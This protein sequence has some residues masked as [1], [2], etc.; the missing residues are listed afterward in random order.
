MDLK[1]NSIADFNLTC[2]DEEV[3]DS[4]F[5]NEDFIKYISRN[6]KTKCKSYLADDMYKYAVTR[7]AETDEIITFIMYHSYASLFEYN[8]TYA[9]NPNYTGRGLTVKSLEL[10]KNFLQVESEIKALMAYVEHTNVPSL[11][12]LHKLKFELERTNKK[13]TASTLCYKFKR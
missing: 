11:K 9:T 12:V 1:L 4:I 6:P 2:K 3:L 10:F 5:E 7:C 8:I 13:G